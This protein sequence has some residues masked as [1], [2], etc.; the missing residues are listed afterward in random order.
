[1]D[2]KILAFG[3]VMGRI[4]MPDFLRIRQ[5]IPG[6]AVITFAGGEIN[7]LASLSILGLKTDFITA[8]PD[9]DVTDAFIGNVRS[10][11]VG[12]QFVFKKPGRFG[13]FFVENGANQRGS[14]VIYDRD[15]SSIALTKPQDYNW[16]EIFKDCGWFHITGITPAL[17]ENAAIAAQEAVE[18]AKKAGITVSCDLNFRKKLWKWDKTAKTAQELARKTMSKIVPFVDI[19]IGNEEDADDVLNIQAG[20]T[21]V[22]SG[23]LEIDKYP[24]VARKIVKQYPNVKKVAFTLRESISASHNNWGA[25]LYD[26]KSD[27]ANFAPLN[28]GAYEPYQIKNIVDRIG[29]GDSFS[30]GLI[31]SLLD[32]EFSK[33][34]S[35]CVAFAA[36]ASCLCHSVYGD[37]NYVKKSEILPLMKGNASGRVNR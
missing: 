18:A 23:K 31:Y 27:K 6:N 1:M 37:F 9:N 2:K 29:G 32:A 8:L 17:S 33:D 25:M 26:A 28:N 15:Y 22:T 24:E 4:N 10:V 12:T 19:V 7:V 35:Q 13:L 30:A 3:E 14:N 5:S 21:D 34:D 36:A 11:G 20:N 16:S